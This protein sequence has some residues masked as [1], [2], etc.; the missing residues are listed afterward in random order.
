M[1]R[2]VA[3]LVATWFAFSVLASCSDDAKDKVKDVASTV[4]DKVGEAGAGALAEALRG[5][6]AAKDLPKGQTERDVDVINQ[7]VRDL[8][9]NPD[10][11]GIEDANG[12]GKDDDGKVQANVGDQSACLNISASGDMNVDGGAC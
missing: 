10:F 12:D 5:A 4:Q 1:R 2:F 8:P 6:L 7:V 3:A 11:T 9:G